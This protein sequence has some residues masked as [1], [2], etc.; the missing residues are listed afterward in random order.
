MVL[1]TPVLA[2]VTPPSVELCHSL[3]IPNNADAPLAV[4]VK[5]E[6]EQPLVLEIEAVAAA[7]APEQPVVK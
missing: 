3:V 5:T 6:L 2:Q 1:L 7:G 4:N